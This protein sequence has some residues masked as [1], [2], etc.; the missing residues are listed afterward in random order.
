MVLLIGRVILWASCASHVLTGREL[1]AA[2]EIEM[3]TIVSFLGS[4]Y[5]CGPTGDQLG[6]DFGGDGACRPLI[7]R[8]R[9]PLHRAL[10]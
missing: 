7:P 4:L 3:R 2:V 5:V 10:G 6:Q 1:G 9:G 8:F